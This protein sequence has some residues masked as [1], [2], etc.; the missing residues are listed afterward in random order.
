MMKIHFLLILSVL[1]LFILA[2]PLQSNILAEESE[3]GTKS[4]NI[5][6]ITGRS[7]SQN[8]SYQL[9][10]FNWQ[11]L[12]ISSGGTYILTSP[13]TSLDSS[14]GCCCSYLPCVFKN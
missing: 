2:I 9:T 13:N 8:K 6:L 4:V 10:G 1:L 11:V 14:D 3:P 7:E 12:G 5:M